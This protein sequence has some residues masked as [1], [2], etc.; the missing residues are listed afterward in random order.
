[1]FQHK[2]FEAHTAKEFIPD[3]ILEIN[4]NETKY[5]NVDFTS[6]ELFVGDCE[7]ISVSGYAQGADSACSKDIEFNFVAS[8]DGVNWDTVSLITLRVALNGTNRVQGSAIVNVGGFKKLR[9][10]SIKNTETTAGYIANNVNCIYG[11]KF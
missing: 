6:R 7:Y 4:P 8:S 10:E 9:L 1:M 3:D 2:K 11:K 5:N